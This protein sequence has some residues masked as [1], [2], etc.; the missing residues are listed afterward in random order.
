[1]LK[2]QRPVPCLFAAAATAAGPSTTPAPI[3]DTT[4]APIS[5]T[6]TTPAPAT[7]TTTI[8]GYVG[9]YQDSKATRIFSV[10][11][12]VSFTSMNAAVSSAK[13]AASA[14]AFL[15]FPGFRGLPCISL[16][17]VSH[18]CVLT[19]STRTLHHASKCRRIQGSLRDPLQTLLPEMHDDP[20]NLLLP[21]INPPPSGLLLSLG[22]SFRDVAPPPPALP[23]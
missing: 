1:M 21:N 17:R 8:E 4:P 23:R 13:E 2:Q 9:C 6:T 14:E 10:Q 3:T 16:S 15:F 18:D 5:P 11:E 7:P 12:D 19:S 20:P 22:C